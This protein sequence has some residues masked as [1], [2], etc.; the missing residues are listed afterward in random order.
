MKHLFVPYEIALLAKK[1]GFDEPC[2]KL[3]EKTELYTFLVDVSEFKQVVKERYTKAPVYQQLIDWFRE[4][5]KIAVGINHWNKEFLECLG[6]KDSGEFEVYV[7]KMERG[8]GS[9]YFLES[10]DDYYFILN[11]G[12]KEAF[13]LVKS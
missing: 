1:N 12:L 7:D 10:S 6:G 3:W 5:H 8:V 2:L 13:K 4:K 11:K 9:I